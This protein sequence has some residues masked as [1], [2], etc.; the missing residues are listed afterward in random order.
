MTQ[1][2]LTKHQV[3]MM[4]N[5]LGL[6][7]SKLGAAYRNFFYAGVADLA[8]WDDLVARGLASPIR[9][10]QLGRQYA[11]TW[12]GFLA[13]SLPHETCEDIHFPGGMPCPSSST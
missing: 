8:A 5:A 10:A 11:V 1:D 13:V 9:D 2:S 4:R 3:T 7:T 6:G 12:D